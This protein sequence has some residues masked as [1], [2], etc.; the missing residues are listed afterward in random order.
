[1][2]LDRALAARGV[3]RSRT[4]AQ[5]LIAAGSVLIDGVVARRSSLEVDED[6][7][8]ALAPTADAYV[9]RGAHKLIGALDAFAL[10]GLTVAGRACLDAGASTGGFT[11]V[12]LE[13]GAAS[14][15]AIDVGHGQMAASIA[16]DPRV[17]S[18]EGVNVRDL[19]PPDQGAGVDEA[20]VDLI[21]AD[22]SFISLSF[23]V[24]PLAA[25]LRPGGDMLLMVKPQF[26]VGAGRL[27]RGGVVRRPEDMVDAVA[28]VARSMA[29]AGFGIADVSRSLVSGPRGTVEFFVWGRR[30]WQAGGEVQPLDEK[31]LQTVIEREVETSA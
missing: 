31:A 9:S 21:V 4:H 13:R 6:A 27:G 14:V 18:R 1:M 16:E 12:L 30:T 25:W 26:E 15:L 10:R 24:E 19:E 11:Q 7:E 17:T 5:A 22:L 23:A 8:I 29:A 20:G 28:S 2:R 3:A